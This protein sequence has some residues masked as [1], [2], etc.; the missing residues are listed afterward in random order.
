MTE[1][2]A[3]NDDKVIQRRQRVSCDTAWCLDPTGPEA[4]KDSSVT[5]TNTLLQTRSWDI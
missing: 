1:A 3:R 4:P 5:S 2:T